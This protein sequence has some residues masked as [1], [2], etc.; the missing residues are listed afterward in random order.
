MTSS[1]KQRRK[2]RKAA[3]LAAAA[4]NNISG[5]YTSQPLGVMLEAKFLVVIERPKRFQIFE[6]VMVLPL[7]LKYFVMRSLPTVQKQQ[8]LEYPRV[9]VQMWC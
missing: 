4:N 7:P 5:D 3:K 9:M 8:P 2:Q 6:R 1:K